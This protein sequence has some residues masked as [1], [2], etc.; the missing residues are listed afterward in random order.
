[1]NIDELY[2]KLL[3][4]IQE[5]IGDYDETD[6]FQLETVCY[7]LFGH[8]FGGILAIDELS[9]INKRQMGYYIVNL[10]PR[11]KGGSHW[12]AIVKTPD[13]LC[14]YDSFGRETHKIISDKYLSKLDPIIHTMTQND[15][16][17]S[18][19]E[20]NCGQRCIAWLIIFDKYGW[21]QAKKI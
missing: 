4:K 15:P 7:D 1:M 16:E 9:E 12:I 18:I 13:M 20:Q 19:Y 5:S 21:K 10:D 2:N 6:N 17:Q 11:S 8:K 3:M 14:V